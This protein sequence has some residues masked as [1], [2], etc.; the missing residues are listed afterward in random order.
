MNFSGKRILVTGGTR[1]I[2]RGIV[3]AFLESG[4][5]V[6]VNGTTAE[7]TAKVLHELRHGARL[8]S[9]PGSVATVVGCQTIV[10]AAVKGLGGLDVLVNNAGIATSGQSL[11]RATEAC[12]DDTI[13]ANLKGVFFM[14]KFAVPVLRATKGN[15]VNIASTSG[16]TADSFFSIYCI[17]KA[18]VIHLTR[19]HALELGP[20]IRV[21]AVCPGPIETD[22]LRYAM[23]ETDG[24]LEAGRKSWAAGVTGLKRIGTVREV[25]AS[26]LFLAS[27]L[28]SY[29]TG[30]TQVIDGGQSLD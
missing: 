15:I 1:G 28:A 26:V 9:A 17:S 19:C 18:A 13:N 4:A 30:T 27:D 29:M 5:H 3:E 6:A 8:I 25:V 10:D 24:N 20:E 7:S 16:I 21:N 11:E 22:M 2:G 14:T 23:V 12:W